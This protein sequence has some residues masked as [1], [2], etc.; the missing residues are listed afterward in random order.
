MKLDR[1]TNGDGRGKYALLKL[2]ALADMAD[3]ADPFQDLPPKIADAISVLDKAG[4]IDWGPAGTEAEFFVLRL[5]DKYAGAALDTYAMQAV[6]DDAE[7]AAEVMKLS[8][9]AGSNSPWC[10]R[11]D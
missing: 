9:R 11:P 2:R 10:K 8:K 3:T 5:K 4:V 1:N 6:G 7:Y